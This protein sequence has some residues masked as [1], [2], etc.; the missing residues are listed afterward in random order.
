MSRVCT[1]N[2][3]K[4]RAE[5]LELAYHRRKV[6]DQKSGDGGKDATLRQDAVKICKGEDF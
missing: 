6:E 2:N 3:C 5:R 1:K 4:I